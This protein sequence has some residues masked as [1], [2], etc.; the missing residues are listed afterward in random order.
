MEAHRILFLAWARF[1]LVL[2]PYAVLLG[3]VGV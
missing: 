2:T 3:P 1:L